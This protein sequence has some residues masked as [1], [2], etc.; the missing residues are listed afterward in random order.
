M[1]SRKLLHLN[2]EIPE[3]RP[4]RAWHVLR[5]DLVYQTTEIFGCRTEQTVFDTNDTRA[6]RTEAI[7]VVD[8]TCIAAQEHRSR[9]V[10]GGEVL[11]NVRERQGS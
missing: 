7:K 1:N 5:R 11:R 10:H 8:F 9:A 4:Q 3:R 2:V 6:A